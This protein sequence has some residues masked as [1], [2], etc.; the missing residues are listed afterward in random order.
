MRRSL[1]N[2]ILARFV[3][4]N[5]RNKKDNET[6]IK[7]SCCL[8]GKGYVAGSS[9]FVFVRKNKLRMRKTMNSRY[10]SVEIKCTFK[11]FAV[12]SFCK[13]FEILR[14]IRGLLDKLV[15]VFVQWRTEK[16]RISRDIALKGKEKMNE[17]AF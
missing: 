8:Y 12:E 6:G 17:K 5:G 11:C 2:K 15:A 13:S 9:L 3:W 1:P 7:S 10:G 14:N 16:I 4:D